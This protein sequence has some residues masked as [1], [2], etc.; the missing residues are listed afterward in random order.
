MKC[1]LLLLL[2]FSTLSYG[3]FN[4]PEKQKPFAD[5]EPHKMESKI[6]LKLYPIW[7]LYGIRGE[8]GFSLMKGI[9]I[10]LGAATYYKSF[11]T[12]DNRPNY[13]P[14]VTYE[15]TDGY[16]F[17]ISVDK[18]LKSEFISLGAFYQY[19]IRSSEPYIL[20]TNGDD[21]V[22]EQST[23]VNN[24][25]AVIYRVRI[26]TKGFYFESHFI[27]G[28]TNRLGKNVITTDSIYPQVR[29]TETSYYK[30]YLP[31]LRPGVAIGFA[32]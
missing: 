21:E 24:T 14:N 15:N 7:F 23:V 17:N 18:N 4:H 32:L 31:Y 20:Y 27:L 11:Y 5:I 25:F 10:N 12:R 19:K 30:S 6:R 8:V 26:P 13:F 2:F 3:Q 16:T 1:F 28:L 9:N 22:S 29:K